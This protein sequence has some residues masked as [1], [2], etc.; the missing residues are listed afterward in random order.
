M[1]TQ[2]PSWLGESPAPDEPEIRLPVSSELRKLNL[3][4]AHQTF[5]LIFEDTIDRLTAGHLLSDIV[6][7]YNESHPIQITLAKFQQWIFRDKE[8]KRRYD[9]AM[10]LGT[11]I[12]LDEMIRIADGR[13]NPMEDVQRSMVRIKVRERKLKAY[14]RKVFGDDPNSVAGAANGPITINIT[15]VD[16]PYA[17]KPVT[18][19]A[20]EDTVVKSIISTS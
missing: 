17:K 9:E 16:S 18:I 19:D 15:G 4:L 2:I 6:I 5:D 11:H 12:T 13:D 10:E 3:E 8:R 7:D 14:N 1:E 20:V